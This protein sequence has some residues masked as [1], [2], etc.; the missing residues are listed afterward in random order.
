MTY[1]TKQLNQ[2]THLTPAAAL[3]A[4]MP[5]ALVAVFAAVAWVV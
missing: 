3:V 2:L 5:S 4:A 1:L